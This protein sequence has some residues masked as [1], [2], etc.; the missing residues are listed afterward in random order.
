MVNVVYAS[1]ATSLTSVS[2]GTLQADDSVLSDQNAT[3]LVGAR[4]QF[5][6]ERGPLHCVTV[7]SF[8]TPVAVLARRVVLTNAT[9][10]KTRTVK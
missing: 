9:T 10:C 7:V 6:V 1:H 5:A 3:A 4:T 2:L 8:R